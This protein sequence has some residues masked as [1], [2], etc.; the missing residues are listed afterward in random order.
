MAE[1]RW[2]LYPRPE[3][4]R[5][6]GGKVEYKDPI[7]GISI[8]D[9]ARAF[10]RFSRVQALAKRS[11]FPGSKWMSACGWPSSGQFFA[12]DEGVRFERLF[13]TVRAVPR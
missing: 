11:P 4:F 8:A 12:E 1:G 7:G 9:L 6:P 10:Q 5:P 3:V 13:R 2:G